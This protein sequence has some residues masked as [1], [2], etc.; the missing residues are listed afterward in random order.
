MFHV[1]RIGYPIFAILL[2]LALDTT[3]SAQA[4]NPAKQ[5]ARAQLIA[6]LRSAHKLLVAADHDYNGHRA[7]AA[8]EVHQALQELGFHHKKPQPGSPAQNAAVAGAKA[9]HAAQARMHEPQAA[10]DAQL[11]QAQQL[12][13]GALTQLTATHPK[14]TTNVQNA[15]TEITTALSIK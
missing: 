11:Q 13:Q 3:A 12:L 10:S 2:G 1:R 14:A 15:I 5:A 6:T 9:A 7:K 4:A 8:H